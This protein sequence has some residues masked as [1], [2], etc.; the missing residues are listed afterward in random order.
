MTSTIDT[1]SSYTSQFGW[2]DDKGA[3][4]A[5]SEKD[6][7]SEIDGIGQIARSGAYLFC[8]HNTMPTVISMGMWN[9]AIALTE[10]YICSPTSGE[11]NNTKSYRQWKIIGDTMVLSLSIN[12]AKRKPNRTVT[13]NGA[14]HSEQGYSSEHMDGME[15]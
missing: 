10:A 8:S 15:Q 1:S 13:I 9:R 7:Y 11:T 5:N 14:W 3:P 6:S 2:L 4:R 12:G